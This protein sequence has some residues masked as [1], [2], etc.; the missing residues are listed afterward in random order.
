MDPMHQMSSIHRRKLRQKSFAW[1]TKK[2]KRMKKRKK[3][4]ENK[5]VKREVEQGMT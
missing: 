4:E 2:T 3:N 5:N 1:E